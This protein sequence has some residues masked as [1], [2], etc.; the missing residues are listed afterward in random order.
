[1][2]RQISQLPLEFCREVIQEIGAKGEKWLPLSDDRVEIA[3]SDVLKLIKDACRES[4]GKGDNDAVDAWLFL[5]DE[6][7]PEPTTGRHDS[8]WAY[9]RDLQPANLGVRNPKY[10]RADIALQHRG[11]PQS[12]VDYPP[13]WRNVINRSAESLYL[14]MRS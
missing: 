6:F 1:M 5:L 13:N 9:I 11:A 3:L 4:L 2:R 7:S 14:Q 12:T 10:E 8:L